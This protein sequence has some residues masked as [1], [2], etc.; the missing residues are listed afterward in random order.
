MTGN[1][2]MIITLPKNTFAAA[3]I[4]TLL[5]SA[6]D[7]GNSNTTPQTA[8]ESAAQTPAKPDKPKKAAQAYRRVKKTY[9]GQTI[10]LLEMD[11][12]PLRD[13]PLTTI[14]RDAEAGDPNSEYELGRRLGAGEGVDRPP[15]ANNP[16]TGRTFQ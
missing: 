11:D 4:A 8:T 2:K 5:F 16:I 15:I 9:N 10:Y 3:C 7:N 14:R 13:V 1:R 6:C 12:F